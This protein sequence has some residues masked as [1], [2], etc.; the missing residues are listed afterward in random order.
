MTELSKNTQ[1]PQCDK[2]AV[3]TRL[4]DNSVSDTELQ[5]LL[6]HF[7]I[8]N[9]LKKVKIKTDF[10]EILTSKYPDEYTEKDDLFF[11]KYAGKEVLVYKYANNVEYVDWFILEDNNYPIEQDCFVNE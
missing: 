1:V 4:L 5:N 9:Q 8:C 3:I 2:T 6:I 7:K 11:N 10:K